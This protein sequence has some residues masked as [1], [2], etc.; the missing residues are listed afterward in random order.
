MSSNTYSQ[1]PNWLYQGKP[2]YTKETNDPSWDLSDLPDLPNTSKYSS[3]NT[4]SVMAYP[5]NE[6]ASAIPINVSRYN[7]AEYSSRDD[8]ENR[9]DISQLSHLVDVPRIDKIISDFVEDILRSYTIYAQ[10]SGGKYRR[11][12]KL[13][14]IAKEP[15]GRGRKLYYFELDKWPLTNM[16]SLL[17]DPNEYV[18]SKGHKS[19]SKGGKKKR[20]T[21]KIKYSR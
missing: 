19:K 2:V 15:G 18:G 4:P 7:A 16:D 6:P 12:G 11:L 3:S 21:R 9:I 1:I 8:D 10:G 5:V 20:K 13:I 17:Y 14:K